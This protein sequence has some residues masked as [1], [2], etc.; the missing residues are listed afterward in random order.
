MENFRLKNKWIY[1]GY[2]I[3][4]W[5]LG[6]LIFYCILN[7]ITQVPKEGA[8]F[9]Y[10]YSSYML[11]GILIGWMHSRT[12]YAVRN[13][14]LQLRTPHLLLKTV[15]LQDIIKTDHYT[16]TKFDVIHGWYNV[17]LTLQKGKKVYLY[18][19]DEKK[20]IALLEERNNAT[21]FIND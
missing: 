10:P 15:V 12:Y 6:G 3:L 1:G 7:M 21:A 9:L 11:S 17:C 19:K 20:L 5:F 16:S 18:A 14:I 13:D 2:I 8:S 4:W